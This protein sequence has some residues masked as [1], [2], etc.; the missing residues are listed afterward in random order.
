M[1]TVVG[2]ATYAEELTVATFIPP[3][4][5]VSSS[6][7]KWFGEEIDRR[8]GGTLTM[9]LFPAGQLG[10]GPVQQYKRVVEGVADITFGL[11]AYTPTLFPRSML[12]IPPGQGQRVWILPNA[13]WRFT[14]SIWPKNITM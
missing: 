8:S 5:H 14:T 12:I 9:Q 4:H 1:A 3:Q 10:A 6:L 2:A 13:C 7:F 11:Q